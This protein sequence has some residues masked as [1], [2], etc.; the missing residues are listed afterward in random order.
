MKIRSGLIFLFVVICLSSLPAINIFGKMVPAGQ[1]TADTSKYISPFHDDNERCFQCHGQ[2]KYE[3]PNENLGIQVKD[4][5][6]SE[7][8]IGRDVFYESNHKSFSCTDCHSESYTSFPHPGELRMEL[9]YNCID[10]HGGDE[11]Y[12]MFN[13][14]Q[15]E[16]EYQQSTH[17]KLEDEG[18]T[19]WSC[20]DPHTYKINIRNSSNLKETILYDNQICLSCH[21]DFQRFQVMSEKDE[22][23]LLKTHDWL[24]NQS[25]HFASV[26]CIE[27]H[28]RLSDSILVAHEIRPK[29]EAV[30]GCNECH[31]GNSILMAS[32]YKFQSKE[33]RSDGF[34]NG[35]ILNESYVIG[36]TR[37]QYLNVLSV[38]LFSLV[39][40]VIVVH[41]F[42]RMK[43]P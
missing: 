39:L 6:W 19:C 18:F 7:G 20:H 23:N 24:P 14:E 13:F 41:V 5:M 37:N 32:L 36:A 8:I 26:R 35:I 15:I 11:N 2:P 27:C 16:A 25:A 28:T 22:I 33:Q 34:I 9:K 31:S 4:Q 12:A 43:K 10:C 30:K 17:F 3:Y 40:I 42:F 38:I 21:S 1:S 29:A